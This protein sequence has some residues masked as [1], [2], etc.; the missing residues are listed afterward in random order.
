MK[1]ACIDVTT[2]RRVLRLRMGNSISSCG[3]PKKGFFHVVGLAKQE[4]H[5][6][7]KIYG[8]DILTGK[9]LPLETKNPEVKYSTT[10]NCGGGS[11][12]RGI[13]Q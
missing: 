6:S 7:V 13:M 11:V 2:A 10:Q 12:S 9:I 8:Y 5:F 1:G 3:Q 4:H